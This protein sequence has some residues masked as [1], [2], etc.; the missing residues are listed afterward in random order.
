M[1]NKFLFCVFAAVLCIVVHS[2]RADDDGPKKLPRFAT[3]GMW[4]AQVPLA[5]VH[6]DLGAFA[7]FLLERGHSADSGVG[8]LS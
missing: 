1:K 2:A 5:R 6:A 7:S 4:L 3:L 8:G